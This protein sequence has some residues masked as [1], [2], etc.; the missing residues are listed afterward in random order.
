MLEFAALKEIKVFKSNKTKQMIGYFI[1]KN[2]GKINYTILLKLL[3]ISDRQSLDERGF[4]MTYDSYV[5]MKNGPVLSCTYNEI[6]NTKTNGTGNSLWRSNLHRS[7]TNQYFV[8]WSGDYEYGLLS[9]SDLGVLN[10]VWEEF[11]D[12]D[13]WALIDYVHTFKEWECPGPSSR[14]ISYQK[15]LTTLGYDEEEAEEIS[16]EIIHE[17][18]IGDFLKSL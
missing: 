11:K 18:S 9:E 1:E 5:S 8:T 6:K 13:L 16:E 4:P 3:Y 17:Q 15:L 2:D 10:K 14:P 12:V 7:D